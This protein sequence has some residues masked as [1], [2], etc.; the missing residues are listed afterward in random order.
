MTGVTEKRILLKDYVDKEPLFGSGHRLCAGC[1]QGTAAKIVSMAFDKPTVVCNATGCLEVAST[2]YPFSAWKVPWI[3]VAFENAAAVASGVL[4]GYDAMRRRGAFKHDKV[5]IV[6][7]GGDGGTYDIGLQALSGAL[8]RGDD[9]LYICYD[10][11]GYMNT[12]IQRSGATLKYAT[13]TT[14][15]A[16]IYVPGNPRKVS[17]KKSILD[18]AIAH[19]LEFAASAS[20]AYPQDLIKKVRTGLD[21]E[22]PAFLL[23]DV[24]CTLGWGVDAAKTI[25]YS[26]TAVESGIFPIMTYKKGRYYL[27]G[28]SGQIWRKEKDTGESARIPAEKYLEGQGRFRHLFRPKKRDELIADFQQLVDFRWE[29]LK[30]KVDASAVLKVD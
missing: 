3:H 18:I 14:S 6:A 12:G 2:I 8:E 15:P 16:G 4:A 5:D 29:N 24:P 28:K 21:V 17:Y 22:G 7:Q 23:V 26:R 1:A 27:D 11:G 25:Y 20:P 9:M 30:R 13:T 10:N 19:G